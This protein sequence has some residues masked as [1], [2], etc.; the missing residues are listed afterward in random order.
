MNNE[1]KS[2]EFE[3]FV[4]K[5]AENLGLLKEASEELELYRKN[6][7]IEYLFCTYKFVESIKK[8]IF[9]YPILKMAGGTSVCAYVL[10]IHSVNPIK[11]GLSNKFFFQRHYKYNLP[12]RFDVTVPKSKM[13]DAIKLLNQ[14]SSNTVEVFIGGLYRFGDKKQFTIGVYGSNYLERCLQ[15]LNIVKSYQYGY[16]CYEDEPEFI[17]Y[18]LEDDRKGFCLPNLAGCVPVSLS[19]LYEYMDAAKPKTL[20]DLAMLISLGES[21]FKDE[22]L[23]LKCLREYGLEDTICSREQALNLLSRYDIDEDRALVILDTLFAGDTLFESDRLLLESNEVPSYL[24]EQL[25][26]IRYLSHLAFAL[27]EIRIVYKIVTGKKWF[28]DD[29]EKILSTPYPHSFVGPFFYIDGRIFSHRDQLT[30]FDRLTRFFDDPVS[31]FEYFSSLGIDGDYGN[32]PRGRVIFDNFHRKFIVYI[33]KVLDKKDI[34][35]SIK[36]T[37]CLEEGRIVFKRDSHYT[38]D[39]L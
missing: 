2:E 23:I 14:L 21:V 10:G 4:L 36:L 33:D 34:K 7:Q 38:H 1:F 19:R 3:K 31:H 13:E 29:F 24:I 9:E 11:Y 6:K 32:Y 22:N 35:E 30:N 27:Q 37:Y 28:V 20:D 16:E 12:P 5:K 25:V 17:N 18:I 15:S 39:N 8:E 26:N